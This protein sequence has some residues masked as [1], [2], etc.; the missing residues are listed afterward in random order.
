LIANLIS[1]PFTLVICEKFDSAARIARALG[2]DNVRIVSLDGIRFLEVFSG[3]DQ[4]YIICSAI[5][6][7]YGLTDVTRSYNTYPTFDIEW[8][9]LY[10]KRRQLKKLKL[11]IKAISK[12]SKSATNFVH[13]CDYDQEGEVIGFNI[14]EYACKQKYDKCLR[15]KFS[16]LTDEEIRSSFD[17]LSPPNRRLAE[18]G[19]CRHVIDFIYGVNLSRALLHS[20]RIKSKDRFHNIS[21]GRVQ[22]PTLAFIVLKE[23]EIKKHV[24]VPYWV[25]YATFKKNGYVVKAYYIK[26]K[27]A[28]LAEANSVFNNCIGKAGI[29][30]E[31]KV[32]KV[33]VD[34]PSPFSLGDLQRE[35]Y[36]LFSISPKDTLS[37]AERLYLNA[38]I[39]YPRTSSQKLPATINFNGILSNLS[40]INEIYNSFAR[41]LLSK[42]KGLSPTNGGGEDPAHPAIF[43]TGVRPKRTLIHPELCV[44]DLIVKRFFATFG[45]PFTI[46][47][48]TLLIE[49]ND[50]YI[51]KTQGKKQL[52]KGW[53]HFYQPYF[54]LG[55]A[56]LPIL[57]C[58]DILEYDTMTILEKFTQAQARFNPSSL[59]LTMIREDIGTKSTRADIIDILKSRNYIYSHKD[60]TLEAT[61]LGMV[62]IELLGKYAP[63]I[64]STRFTRIME[65]QLGDIESG[66]DSYA[67]VIKY[68]VNSL[69]ESLILLK[70]NESDIGLRISN[71]AKLLSNR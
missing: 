28:T 68:A 57:K 47:N 45:D 42:T 30:K 34:P 61:A 27:I 7:L 29:I 33:I 53:T 43:P 11:L 44:Y 13:A 49:V 14:L 62:V 26:E 5:G 59:L 10:S 52:D 51:F 58:H 6:H 8:V 65:A 48:T 40:Q 66:H 3:K 16:T 4:H 67:S 15:A 54:K 70:K 71:A 17:S 25:L 35:A 19:R 2:K 9:P 18:A 20:F 38:L 41:L 21:I 50:E 64:I 56:I 55:E 12:I 1:K 24:P 37:I 69:I 36:R 46:L 22:G 23:I 32:E 31:L 39:S 60:G 63:E